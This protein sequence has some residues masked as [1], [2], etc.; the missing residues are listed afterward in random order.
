MCNVLSPSKAIRKYCLWCCNNQSKEVM[1]CVQTDCSLYFWR[2]GRALR[3]GDI[4]YL[5][6]R[7]QYKKV[8]DGGHVYIFNPDGM[9]S[10]IIEKQ[11]TLTIERQGSPI[12]CTKKRCSD[13]AGFEYEKV[14]TCEFDG[15]NEDFCDLYPYRMGKNPNRL[16]I[17]NRNPKLALKY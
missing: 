15:K 3:D 12:K 16:G 9:N 13:C 8:G 2:Y 10:E 4:I 14:K 5:G 17:G 6:E 11:A 1:L 7:C